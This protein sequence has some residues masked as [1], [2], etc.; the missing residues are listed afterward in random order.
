MDFKEPDQKVVKQGYRDSDTMYI[1][2][3]GACKVTIY[4]WS[5]SRGKMD[6]IQVRELNVSDY[7]GEIS[8]IYDSVR[9]ATVTC[10]N[11]VTLGKLNIKTL[12]K[13]CSNYP[14][15]LSAFLQ[16]THNYDDQLRIFLSSIL[17]DIPYL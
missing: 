7:F 6:D 4:D 8:M 11:Y 5:F 10:K 16:S 3:Q 17:R 12:Y 9:T 2:S 14:Y 15:F 13:I 1:I